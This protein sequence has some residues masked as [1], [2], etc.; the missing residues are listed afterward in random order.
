M[1]YFDTESEVKQM[2]FA[3]TLKNRRLEL[4]LTQDD[5]AA[6]FNEEFSRQS[7]SKWENGK[8]YPEVDQLLI[9]SVK[10]DI[11]LDKLFADELAYLKHSKDDDF[12][13]KYPGAVTA[14]KLLARYLEKV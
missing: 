8:N 3:E 4:G 2:G 12:E 10:L 14:L 7:V 1:L 9:L 6:L 13:E 11:S 5:V